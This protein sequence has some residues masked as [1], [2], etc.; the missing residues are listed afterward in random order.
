VLGFRGGLVGGLRSGDEGDA[1]VVVVVV[2]LRARRGKTA[3]VEDEDTR[4]RLLLNLKAARELAF[5]LAAPPSVNYMA[6]SGVLLPPGYCRNNSTA[7]SK[8]YS[9]LPESPWHRYGTRATRSTSNPIGTSTESIRL[10]RLV[11]SARQAAAAASE[12]LPLSEAVTAA[13]G[14]LVPPTSSR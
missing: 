12:P 14:V 2:L 9:A 10:L 4:V 1:V 11:C 3:R 6:A 13:A 8:A 7:S 5:T